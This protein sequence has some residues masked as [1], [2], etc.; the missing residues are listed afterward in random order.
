VEKP[1]ALPKR[2]YRLFAAHALLL[3]TDVQRI[4]ISLGI[5]RPDVERNR[6]RA[7]RRNSGAQRV[8]AQVS[9]RDPQPSGALIANPRMR[10]RVTTMIDGSPISVFVNIFS[11]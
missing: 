8:E 4:V 7:E 9:N 2:T 6:Q 11:I 10:S 5:I 3:H 1:A